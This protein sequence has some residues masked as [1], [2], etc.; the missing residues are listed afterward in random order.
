[1]RTFDE[2]LSYLITHKGPGETVVLTVLRGE[3]RTDL[4]VTLGKRP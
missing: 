2:L 1:V 4:T 3:E